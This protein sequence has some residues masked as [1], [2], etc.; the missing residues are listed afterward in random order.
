MNCTAE[1][2]AD[3]VEVWAPTQ[4]QSDAVAA[5]AKA[6]GIGGGQG[7]PAHDLSRRRLRPA[8]RIRFRRR[9][10]DAGQARRQARAGPVVARG[11][12]PAR[13]LPPRGAGARSKAASTRPAV[14]PRCASP[15]PANR[16]SRACSRPRP[17]S[18][19]MPRSSR[20]R[21][22]RPTRLPA[23]ASTSRWSTTRCPWAPGAR[24]AIPSPPSPRRVSS[25]KWRM[26]RAPTRSRF[27]WR[28]SPT[29]RA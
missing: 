15:S 20:A 5:A 14:R 28:C 12:H 6:A 25:T 9:G 11:G 18:A 1:V 10:G 24:S 21:S 26:K 19:R 13:F 4:A 22:P 8:P 29:S 17:G 2:G 27:G 7:A 23:S 3:F 16:F